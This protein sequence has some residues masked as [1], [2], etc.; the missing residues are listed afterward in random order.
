MQ[1]A[2][3]WVAYVVECSWTLRRLQTVGPGLIDR[4]NIAMNFPIENVELMECMLA[5]IFRVRWV[6]LVR[7]RQ[8]RRLQQWVLLLACFATA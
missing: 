5:S 8:K 7:G 3:V 6:T 4:S 1:S 2:V